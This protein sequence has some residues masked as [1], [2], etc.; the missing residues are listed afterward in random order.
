LRYA[1]V[2]I[3]PAGL[4]LFGLSLL[5]GDWVWEAMVLFPF[6]MVLSLAAT[7]ILA[8]LRKGGAVALAGG[9]RLEGAAAR[10]ALLMALGL[11]A[12]LVAIAVY[13]DLWAA[14]G[15]AWLRGQL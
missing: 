3:L 8:R 2:L 1:P 6:L 14:Q 5:L 10:R 11:T 13:G 12:L 9:G 4:V 7:P 15:L